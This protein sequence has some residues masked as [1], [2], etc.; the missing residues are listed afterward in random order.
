MWGD[1]EG[2]YSVKA[3]YVEIT[4]REEGL[5]PD[6]RMWKAVWDRAYIPKVICFPMVALRK[7]AVNDG[8][9]AEEREHWPVQVSTL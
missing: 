5:N 2:G 1:T 8:K 9:P 7:Y 4:H 6:K 3:S